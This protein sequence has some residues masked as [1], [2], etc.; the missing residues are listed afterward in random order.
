M[1]N[2]ASVISVRIS[3]SSIVAGIFHS[4]PS[5]IARIV[6]RKTFPDRVFGKRLTTSACLN[7]ATGPI[8]FLTSVTTSPEISTVERVQPAF[9]TRKPRGI[10]PFKASATPV[11]L[12]FS[13][14][15]HDRP[16]GHVWTDF[17]SICKCQCQCTQNRSVW[18]PKISE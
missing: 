14:F 2:S 18:E 17:C 8:R 9:N 15:S 10:C 11:F 16:A 7:A 1:V 13:Y 4:F 6:P 12:P 5:A 3:G